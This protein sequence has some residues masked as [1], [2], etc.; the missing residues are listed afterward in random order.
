[1]QT[2]GLCLISR[3]LLQKILEKSEIRLYSFDGSLSEVTQTS[4]I[5]FFVRFWDGT[6]IC[7][8]VSFYGLRPT[9]FGHGRHTGMLN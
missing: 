2:E 5:D 9:F 6:D 8:K 7:V 3:H 4:E 1:M